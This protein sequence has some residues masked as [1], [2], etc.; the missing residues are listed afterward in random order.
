MLH[1]KEYIFPH[2]SFIGGWYI[3]NTICD[4][5][6]EIFKNNKGNYTSGVV[7]PP[8]LRVDLSVK[9]SLEFAI[10]PS[11]VDPSFIWY[12]KHLKAIIDLY[13]KKY[14]EVEKFNKF[15]LIE[16]AQIQYYR[17]GHGFKKWHSERTNGES[18]RC[19]VF[20]TYLNSVPD[21][22]T[23]FK[24][25]DL[26]TPAEK[27]LTLLWPTDF[28]HTHKGQITNYHEKYIITGW[29]GYY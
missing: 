23:H 12:L 18:R 22:G 4:E 8:P 29:L 6:I 28:T 13:I 17:P 26:T 25:Q 19:L 3:P 20:M 2:K 5:L 11:C 1:L 9:E 27:G 14:P 15:G 24:Y 10:N 16:A 7:G 21:A